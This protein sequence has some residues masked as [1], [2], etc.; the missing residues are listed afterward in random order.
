VLAI[1]GGMLFY[2]FY[3]SPLATFFLAK[4][5]GIAQ[6]GDTPLVWTI[7]FL[8]VVMIQVDFFEGWPLRKTGYSLSSVVRKRKLSDSH[9]SQQTTVF[10]QRPWPDRSGRP[11]QGFRDGLQEAEAEQ[12]L[13]EF[14]DSYESSYSLTLAYPGRDPVLASARQAPHRDGRGAIKK[15]SSKNSSKSTEGCS[16]DA[17]SLFSGQTQRHHS[18]RLLGGHSENPGWP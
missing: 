9:G 7:L 6:P 17:E 13:D 10:S 8:S 3:Y 14:F 15:R 18:E 12:A 11:I 16:I 5:P 4:V 2:W 1:G